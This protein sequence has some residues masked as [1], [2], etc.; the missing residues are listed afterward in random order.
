MLATRDAHG[1]YREYGFTALG[2]PGIFTERK[3]ASYGV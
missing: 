1:L 2:D 3:D